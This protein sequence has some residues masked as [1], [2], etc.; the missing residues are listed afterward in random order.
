MALEQ[1]E[2]T[3]N[4]FSDAV[5]SLTPEAMQVTS[6]LLR[7]WMDTEHEEQHRLVP[8]LQLCRRLANKTRILS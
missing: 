8:A 1:E 7:S 6:T 4:E 3:L 2:I 5:G